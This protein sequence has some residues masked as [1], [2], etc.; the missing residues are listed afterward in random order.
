MISLRQRCDQ[1]ITDGLGLLAVDGGRRVKV[2]FSC[3]KVIV[4]RAKVMIR[5]RRGRELRKH[6]RGK[7]C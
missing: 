1:T 3:A 7:A 5:L 6:V 4:S 2:I